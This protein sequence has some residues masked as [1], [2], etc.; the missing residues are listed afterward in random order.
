MSEETKNADV[1]APWG[2]VVALGTSA[3]VGWGYIMALL[4][5]IQVRRS[6][7][8][9]L[10][11]AT[12]QGRSLHTHMQ[13]AESALVQL[14]CPIT[15]VSRCQNVWHV[16]ISMAT[17]LLWLTDCMCCPGSHRLGNGECKR[18]HDRPDLL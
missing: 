10:K 3:V 12:M 18:V 9:V 16:L 6:R 14:L 8:D 2:I 5:S 15:K 7:P 11:L 1:S 13:R 4:F 17:T